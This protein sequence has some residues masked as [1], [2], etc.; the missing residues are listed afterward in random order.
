LRG[1]QGGLVG[2]TRIAFGTVVAAGT[3]CRRDVL[4]PGKLVFGQTGGRLK[5][6]SYDFKTYGDITRVIKNNLLY[7]G[8]LHALYAWYRHVR[9]LIMADDI[10][11]KACI[12]G[13]ANQIAAMVEERVKRLSQLAGKLE[14]SLEIS[15]VSNGRSGTIQRHEQFVSSWASIAEKLWLPDDDRAEN[16]NRDAFINAVQQIQENN[17]LETIRAISPE[18][19]EQGTLWL[20]KVADSVI[21]LWGEITD[22]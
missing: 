12:A 22:G 3:I 14:K 8:N 21:N 5:E 10:F 16:S 19:K 13:A 6:T 2:P 7:I 4:Q 9:P 18:S 17:Y 11:T 20:Q 1:G 15:G